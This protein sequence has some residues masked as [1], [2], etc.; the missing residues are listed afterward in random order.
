LLHW[1]RAQPALVSGSITLLASDPQVL[2]YVRSGPTQRLLCVFNFSE[3]T[4]KWS[5]PDELSV[6]GELAE[7][8]LRGAQRSGSQLKLAPW[9]G[10]FLQLA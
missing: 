1:R 4:A 9:G 5:V 6:A 3:R 7:S 10:A 8:G 2:A